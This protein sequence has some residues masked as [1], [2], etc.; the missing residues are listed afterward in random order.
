MGGARLIRKFRIETVHE[1]RGSELKPDHKLRI[2]VKH[3]FSRG[4][5]DNEK[6]IVYY[7]LDEDNKMA[8]EQMK[9]SWDALGVWFK[10]FKEHEIIGNY[11]FDKQELINP[12]NN[13]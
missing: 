5:E 10:V 8:S 1:F 7:I 9:Q 6:G 4:T 13:G 2:A 3:H 11:D 12:E